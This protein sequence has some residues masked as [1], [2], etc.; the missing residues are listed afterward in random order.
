MIRSSLL[1]SSGFSPEPVRGHLHFTFFFFLFFLSFFGL[2]WGMLKFLGQGSN[3]CHSSDLSCCS[4]NA[5][6]LTCRATR[7]LPNLHFSNEETK[8][9]RSR[10]TCSDSP[11]WHWVLPRSAEEL[12]EVEENVV[13]LLFGAAFCLQY[14]LATC[15][16]L[17]LASLLSSWSLL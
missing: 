9:Q 1:T 16:F 15:L 13:F 12:G 3:P 7:E 14:F 5:G 4:D 8:A 17:L 6:S 11:C 2:T 10:M